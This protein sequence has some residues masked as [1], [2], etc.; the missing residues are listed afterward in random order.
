M[1]T[2]AWPVLLQRFR[3]NPNAQEMEST[4]IQ[5]NIDATRAAYGLDKL[6]TEQYKVTDKGEQ[7]ALAKEGDTTAQIRL[8]DP[9]V[10]SPTFKQLQQSKQYYTFADT[11][12]VD[13][14]E[15]DGVSQDTVI[16]ARELALA[17]NDNRNWVNDHTVY[18]HGYGVVAAYGNKVTADGQPEFFES[19]IPTQ[20]KLTESEKYEPRIYFSPN[21]TEYSIVGAPEG[22]QA[23]EFDYPTGS[24]GAL[25]TFKATAAPRLATCS[26]VF[27]TQ[28]ASAPIRF[29]SPTV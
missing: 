16:A 13:K 9:Q 14:Y 25:T 19:G 26:P 24:E 3:V 4:Y 18:T 12:A 29:S 2:V 11:L 7:G 21:T 8:L 1:L 10:V 5:R 23:W 28:S 22:T 27:S 15:I 6:K 20:G 17:G